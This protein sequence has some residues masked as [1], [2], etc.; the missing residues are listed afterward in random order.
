MFSVIF[1]MDGTLF[2]TQ[3][4]YIPAWDLIG[5]KYGVE[6]MGRCIPDVCGANEEG[7]KSYIRKNFPSVKVE[8][9]AK[10]VKEYV[11][12]NLVVRY[13]K[14]AEELLKYLKE[15]GVGL[16][17]ASGSSH[18]I[19]DHHLGKVGGRKYFDV[20]VGGADVKNG[21]PAPDIFLLAAK[22]LEVDPSTCIVIEDSA[23]GI[24][25]ATAAGM[26][27]VGIPD[28][29]PFDEE[30]KKILFA[31]FSSMEEAAPLFKELLGEK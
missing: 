18:D 6:N 25:A 17:I 29:A 15:K 20:I 5:E 7:W 1:D 3:S 8:S 21:K 4:I 16:A 22:K 24:K 10:E 13:K 19:I 30:T 11:E 31:E 26:K 27:G 28:I 23:N 12:E 9:F 14:G 2:D